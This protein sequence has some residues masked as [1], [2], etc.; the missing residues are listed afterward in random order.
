MRT[1][2][3]QW[4]VKKGLTFFFSYELEKI[5]RIISIEWIS[6]LKITSEESQMLTVIIPQRLF[7]F[8]RKI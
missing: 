6:W 5:R 8:F 7:F 1:T 2:E 4:E 3:G